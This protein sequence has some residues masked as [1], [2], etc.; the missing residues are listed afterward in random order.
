MK[1]RAFLKATAAAVPAITLG[2]CQN[3][4][5]Q[6]AGAENP[7][8]QLSTKTTVPVLA[9]DSWQTDFGLVEVVPSAWK[10]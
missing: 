7:K 4:R 9:T 5:T 6:D 2:F 8:Y 3:D 10:T 1:R